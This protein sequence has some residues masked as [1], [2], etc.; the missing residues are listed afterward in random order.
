M[1]NKHKQFRILLSI[2]IIFLIII[3]SLSGCA[4]LEKTKTDVKVEK[5][6][7]EVNNES[8]SV[9]ETSKEINDQA[10]IKVQKSE[11]GDAE[12]DKRVNLQV[13]KILSAINLQKKSGDNYMKMYYDLENKIIKMEA[14]I[15]ETTSEDNNT[16]LNTNTETSISEQMM[17]EIIKTKKPWWFYPL[18]IFIAIRLLWPILKPI[19]MMLVS[20]TNILTPILSA[21]KTKEE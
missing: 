15:G 11:T 9:K 14:K 17:E 18:I 3:F 6:K 20:P 2:I 21:L 5:E 10:E 8:T 13:D 16:N 19:L 7:I 12:L 4:T 1:K